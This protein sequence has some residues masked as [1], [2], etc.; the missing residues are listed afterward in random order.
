MAVLKYSAL[1]LGIFAVV[2]FGCLYIDLGRFTLIFAV[3]I[4]LAVSWMVSY[5]FF[6]SW[7]IAAGEQ[8]AGWLG[9]RRRSTSERQ[10]NAAEDEL[11]EQF[12]EPAE[13]PR[14][15]DQD[16]LGRAEG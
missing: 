8:L 16:R 7:R 11:A 3:I 13:Q 14:P 12:H 15:H 6:N 5:L 1:R 9:R 4:G 2:F 10:D